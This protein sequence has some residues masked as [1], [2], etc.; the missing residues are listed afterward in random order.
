MTKTDFFRVATQTWA[1]MRRFPTSD[2]LADA[3][4]LSALFGLLTTPFSFRRYFP[5]KK[6]NWLLLLCNILLT[7]LMLY[8]RFN[9]SLRLRC[10]ERKALHTATSYAG[11]ISLF[12]VNAWFWYFQIRNGPRELT[13]AEREL[14][15]AE[16]IA[17]YESRVE[18]LREQPRQPSNRGQIAWHLLGLALTLNVLFRALLPSTRARFRLP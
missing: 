15:T 7:P 9:L 18:E 12:S 4:M 6:S 1:Q 16:Q 14:L 8:W 11:V 17:A 2:T 5:I 10:D 13:E 3:V